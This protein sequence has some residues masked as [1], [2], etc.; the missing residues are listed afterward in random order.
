M[1]VWHSFNDGGG[2]TVAHWSNEFRVCEGR[3]RANFISI[4]PLSHPPAFISALPSAPSD[5]ALPTAQMP[6]RSISITAVE[7]AEVGM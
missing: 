4:S 1:T 7:E 5:G 3:L 2:G 6:Y